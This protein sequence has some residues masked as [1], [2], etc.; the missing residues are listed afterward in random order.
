M[1]YRRKRTYSR[2][3]QTKRKSSPRRTSRAQTVRVELVIP[4]PSLPTGKMRAPV[5]RQRKPF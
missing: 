1:P 2:S 5:Q 3:R 4:Q